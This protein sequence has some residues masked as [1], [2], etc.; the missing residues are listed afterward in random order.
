M[1]ATPLRFAA[2]A[3]ALLLCA[4]GRSLPKYEKPM[5]RAAVQSVRTTAYTHTEDDHIEHGSRTCM[6]TPLRNG[7]IKSAAADW[8]RWPA[9]TLFRIRETGEYFEVDDIGWA[10]AGRNTIDLYKPSKSAMNAWGVRTVNIEVLR[11]GT[12]RESLD[13]LD[14]RRRH[15]H[16]RRM[17]DDLET[18]VARNTPAAPV[19]AEVP[20]AVPATVAVSTDATAMPVTRPAEVPTG[21]VLRSF[22]QPSGQ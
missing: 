22:R 7:P 10:L 12:D 6:G 20:A 19:Y 4:C 9:G 3:M 13:I 1:S 11:W 15:R 14:K 16:V 2:L 5:A 17:V 8:S 21:S 18:R